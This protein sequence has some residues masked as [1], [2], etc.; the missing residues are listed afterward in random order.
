M[1]RKP[2]LPT[3]V[4]PFTGETRRLGSIPSDPRLV[5]AAPP[6]TGEVLPESELREFD[7]WPSTI[8]IKDQDGKGACNGHAT[9]TACEM[10][11]HVEGEPYV[12]LSAWYVYSILCGGVDRGSNILEAYELIGRDG[13]APEDAVSYGLI[14][15]RKLTAE[16]H[17]AAPRFRMEVGESLTTWRQ[18]VSAVMLRQSLNLAVQVGNRFNSLDSE[19]V[20]GVDRGPGNHAVSVGLRLKKSAKHGWLVGMH[21]SWGTVWGQDGHCYLSEAVIEAVRYFE[22]FS[23]KAVVEDPSDPDNPPIA[24]ALAMAS[25]PRR[26]PWKPPETLSC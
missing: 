12:P 5:A 16:A 11:R 10:A 23:V 6:Y 13:I 15:P 20:V 22:C 4:D 26:S 3:I 14:N 1:A 17:A 9:A 2:D 8:K 19:G 18:I 25:R 24:K 21:N 7:D